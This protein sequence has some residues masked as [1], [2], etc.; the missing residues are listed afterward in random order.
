MSG[1][2][3]AHIVG[4]RISYRVNASS[5]PLNPLVLLEVT[6]IRSSEREYKQNSD[7][8]NL[9]AL[10]SVAPAQLVAV[11]MQSFWKLRYNKTG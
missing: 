5:V 11:C 2:K 3:Y 8:T 10:V 9:T 7:T 1:K 4:T 6:F